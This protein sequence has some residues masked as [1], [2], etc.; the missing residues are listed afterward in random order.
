MFRM[1]TGGPIREQHPSCRTKTKQFTSRCLE[2]SFHATSAEG[3]TQSPTTPMASTRRALAT[4]DTREAFGPKSS[5][6]LRIQFKIHPFRLNMVAKHK[7]KKKKNNT[8]LSK[9]QPATQHL[10][11]FPLLKNSHDFLANS[12]CVGGNNS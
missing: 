12:I 10:W 1:V 2:K 11:H 3:D 9:L 4:G 6:I 5:V 7:L 8:S